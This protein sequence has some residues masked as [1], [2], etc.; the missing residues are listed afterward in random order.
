MGL[1]KKIGYIFTKKQKIRLLILLIIISIGAFIELLGVTAILPFINVIMNPEAIEKTWYLNYAYE[2]FHFQNTNYFAAFLA[3]IL[4]AVY[5][6]KN[7]Y[8]SL[9]YNLQYHFTFSNQRILAYRMLECYMRQP[10]SYHLSHNSAQLMRNVNSDTTMMFQ[11]V[12][13][14]LQLVT[15]AEVCITLGIY[16]FIKDKTITL[17][18]SLFLVIFLAVFAKGFK[19]YL[20][21]IGAEDRKYCAGITQWMQQAFGGIKEIKIA[22]KESFFINNFDFNYK[23]Y[24]TCERKYRFLQVVPRPLTE[25]ICICGLLAIVVFKLLTGTQSSYFVS[26]LSL[27]AVAAVRLL[28]SFNRIT[29]YLSIIMFNLPAVESVYHDLKEI[30]SLPKN[31]LYEK[32]VLP[33]KIKEKIGIKDLY[34][35]YPDAEEYVLKDINFEI[36]KY[37]SVGFVGPSG[38][39]KTTLADIILGALIPTQGQVLVDNISIDG[40]MEA[41]HKNIGYIPQTIYLMDDTIRRNIAFGVPD[42]EIDEKR[43]WDVVEE[44]QLKEFVEALS[45]GLDTQIGERGVRLSGGQR[46]RIGI[47]RALYENPEVL[48]FDEATS[49]LDNE[50]ENAV[51][52]SIES[53]AGSKTIIIIAHRLTT[54]KNCTVIYEVKDGG[55]KKVSFEDISH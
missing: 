20:S 38:A 16:L 41:W 7:L 31:K 19:K 8:V 2:K 43:I 28:P 29:N 40:Q 10:Y 46:Q 36:K 52:T 54:I 44:A 11:A 18:I 30:E 32:N 53:L 27:F 15:E 5:L 47:A 45:D 49:A 12:L 34:F 4:A 22:G 48:V 33:L 25:V 23:N 35:K 13:S 14:S 6:L 21:F 26:T 42:G 1:I 17:G 50:T 51:M 39:G 3:M 24:A 37:Q 55:I 9:M